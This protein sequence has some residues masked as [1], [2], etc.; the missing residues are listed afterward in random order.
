LAGAPQTVE[1]QKHAKFGPISDDFEVRRRMS[2][3]RTKIFKI[4]QSFRVWRFLLRWAKQVRWS[5]V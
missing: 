3:K 5:L 4:G 2:P 1:G